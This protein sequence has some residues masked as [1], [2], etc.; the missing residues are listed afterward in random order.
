MAGLKLVQSEPR[1]LRPCDGTWESLALWFLEFVGSLDRGNLV[2]AADCQKEIERY[3]FK[4]TYRRL[5]TKKGQ[6]AAAR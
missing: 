4:I 1:Q 6:K 3:G 2:A 5:P